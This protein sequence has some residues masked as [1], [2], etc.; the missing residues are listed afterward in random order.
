LIGTRAA[1]TLLA[2]GLLV[3]SFDFAELLLVAGAAFLPTRDFFSIAICGF[4]RFL[5]NCFTQYL[6]QAERQTSRDPAEIF[7]PLKTMEKTMTVWLSRYWNF[8]PGQQMG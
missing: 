3:S 5:F 6:V 7:K 2:A 8:P 4:S 1:T